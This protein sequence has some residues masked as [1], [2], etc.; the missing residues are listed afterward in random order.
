MVTEE[1]VEPGSAATEA[2]KAYLRVEGNDEDGLI[3]SL[4]ASAAS[5]CEAFT[6]QALM[7]RGF[8]ETAERS[9]CWQRLGRTP[10]AAVTAVEEARPD[11][12]YTPVPAASY[13]V[14]IDANGDG[15]VRVDSAVR[16]VRVAYQAGLAA[17]WDALPET[18]RQGIIR[19]AAHLYTQRTDAHA[20][21]PA[22]VT[23]LWRPWRQMRLR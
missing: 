16:R 23:A 15:W 1:P 3:G 12:S 5:L 7:R 11:G 14:D 19:L 21:P 8:S 10:V 17:D 20:A 18:L 9:G 13:A 6:G 2:A 22:A 4:V